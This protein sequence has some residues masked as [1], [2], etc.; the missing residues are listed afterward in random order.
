LRA[1]VFLHRHGEV[2]AAFDGGIVRNDHHLPACDA[3]DAGNDARAGRFAMVHIPGGQ[4][5]NFE[6]GR[7]GIQQ[8]CYA[9]SRQELAPGNVARARGFGPP[10]GR[11]T[12]SCVQLASKLLVAREV[13]PV[14]LG[15]RINLAQEFGHANIGRGPKFSIPRHQSE[16]HSRFAVRSSARLRH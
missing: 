5:T 1:Q 10:Q 13:E 8:A 16:F 11:V 2:G 7:A 4:L 9:V 3:P 15:F 14:G 12:Y 6:E